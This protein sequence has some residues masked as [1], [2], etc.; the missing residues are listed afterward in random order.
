[1]LDM[2]EAKLPPP[3]PESSASNWKTHRGVLGSCNAMPAPIAGIINVAV[4][5]KIVLRPPAMRIKKVLGMRNVA[6]VS[7]AIAV[8]VNSSA[9]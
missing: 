6:P 1:M 9:G 2:D 8:S 4:V 3:K 5:K 7:P